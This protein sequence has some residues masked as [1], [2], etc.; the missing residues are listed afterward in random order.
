M[1]WDLSLAL[2]LP[3]VGIDPFADRLPDEF[4]RYRIGESQARRIEGSEADQT[5]GD[6]V[7]VASEPTDGFEVLVDDLCLA[8]PLTFGGFPRTQR[9][10]Q[11]PIALAGHV[12]EEFLGAPIEMSGGPLEFHAYLI[13]GPKLVP[14]DR[15]GALVRIHGASGTG[16]DDRFLRYQTKETSRLPQTTCE[17]FVRRGLEGALHIDRESFNYAHP[18]IVYLSKWL[19]GALTQLFNV[20]KALSKGATT[21]RR[22]KQQKSHEAALEDAARRVWNAEVGADEEPPQMVFA[23]R[24]DD[25]GSADT[26]DAFVF[27]EDLV[28]PTR[29]SARDTT[30]APRANRPD[31][32]A[33]LQVLEAFGVLSNLSPDDRSRL[34]RALSE[35]LG[36]AKSG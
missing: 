6:A 19:H 12:S 1:V 33:V 9:T 28:A 23:P 24:N 34:A 11:E 27:D 3:Y 16:F 31:L 30:S 14:S 15:A 35:V 10:R 2:P 20:E 26:S 8:R 7:G 36:V 17:I 21:E 4:H 29:I 5:L 22:A 25:S 18:H 32:A 13:W